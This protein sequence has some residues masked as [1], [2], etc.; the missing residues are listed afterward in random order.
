MGL[1]GSGAGH[2][3]FLVSGRSGAERLL[4][5]RAGRACGVLCSDNPEPRQHL[6]GAGKVVKGEERWHGVPGVCE[7]FLGEM[8]CC[9]HVL[10]VLGKI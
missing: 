5:P 1:H 8:P 3:A 4:S 6:G 2:S 7:P 9:A 10:E